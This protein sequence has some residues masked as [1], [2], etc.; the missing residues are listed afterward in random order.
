MKKIFCSIVSLMAFLV[1]PPG[2]WTQEA[3]LTITSP[4][5]AHNQSIPAKYTCQGENVNPPLSIELKNFPTAK[6][7]ALIVEDPDAPSGTW[8]HWILFNIP[9]PESGE[10]SID[11]NSAPGIQGMNDFGKANY[12][13]PCPPMGRHRYFFKAYVLEGMPDLPELKEGISKQ[14]LMEAMDYYTVGQG[15]LIGLYKKE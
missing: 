9:V 15:E 4:V 5:F 14:A 10:V 11:E 7:V 1:Y 12:G 6:Y 8:V 2:G 3:A 13:G